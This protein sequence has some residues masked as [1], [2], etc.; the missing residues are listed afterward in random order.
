MEKEEVI[1]VV[2]G[3][4]ASLKNGTWTHPGVTIAF[5]I[6]FLIALKYLIEKQ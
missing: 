1:K 4:I 2:E 3:T 5:L 6:A